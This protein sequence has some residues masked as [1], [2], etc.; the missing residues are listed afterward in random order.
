M[1][2]IFG[3]PPQ[4]HMLSVVVSGFYCRGSRDGRL[5]RA[6]RAGHRPG[7]VGGPRRGSRA[8]NADV[9][10]GFAGGLWL[11]GR[12]CA[13]TQTARSS[14]WFRHD[15]R[16][17]GHTVSW[18]VGSAAGRTSPHLFCE[19][20]FRQRAKPVGGCAPVLAAVCL[21][22]NVKATP[23]RKRGRIEGYSVTEFSVFGWDLDELHSSQARRG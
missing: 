3:R 2:H 22:P 18:I 1:K 15:R 14:S 11:A 20:N 10:R 4:T 21:F 13:E 5:L 17:F 23:S 7:A 19:P 8:G 16:R 6:L 9:M 12:T